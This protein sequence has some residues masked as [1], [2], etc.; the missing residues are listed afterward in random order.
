MNQPSLGIGVTACATPV[1]AGVAGTPSAAA[2]NDALQDGQPFVIDRG[3]EPGVVNRI[4][5]IPA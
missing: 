4:D 5:R 3:R 1:V 2:E